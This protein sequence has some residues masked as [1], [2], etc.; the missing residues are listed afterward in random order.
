VTNFQVHVCMHICANR[1]SMVNC[2]IV[3]N[4]TMMTFSH[5]NGIDGVQVQLKIKKISAKQLLSYL[6]ERDVNP[7]GNGG[8]IPLSHFKHMK[9]I[10][11]F[12][13]F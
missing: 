9:S 12:A 10:G 5:Q 8:K 11:L 13:P 3:R 7:L 2:V 1:V 4:I 6:G